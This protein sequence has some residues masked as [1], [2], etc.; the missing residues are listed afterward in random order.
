[1]SKTT[2]SGPEIAAQGPGT[3]IRQVKIV[4]S[5]TYQFPMSVRELFSVVGLT[6]NY[7]STIFLH[8]LWKKKLFWPEIGPEIGLKLQI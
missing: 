4:E 1:M 5:S 7:F 2:I 6:K 3:V 8:F